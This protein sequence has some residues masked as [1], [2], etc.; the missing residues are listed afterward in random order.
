MN[1]LIGTGSGRAPV[2]KAP[3]VAVAFVYLGAFVFGQ[4]LWKPYFTYMSEP[5]LLSRACELLPCFF[6]L[7]PKFPEP[8]RIEAE[9]VTPLVY[10]PWRR[11]T[12]NELNSDSGKCN[13]TMVSFH[14]MQQPYELPDNLKGL[15]YNVSIRNSVVTDAWL[16]DG[17]EKE[18]QY[19]CEMLAQVQTLN[20]WH[21]SECLNGACLDASYIRKGAK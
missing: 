14:D 7:N 8:K 1:S 5:T 4:L 6:F 18:Q 19:F 13:L 17:S 9:L 16:A 20:E 15:G 11:G 21:W 3:V 2:R 10:V 12:L